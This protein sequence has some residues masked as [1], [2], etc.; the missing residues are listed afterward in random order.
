MAAT[1][2]LARAHGWRARCRLCSVLLVRSNLVTGKSFYIEIEHRVL[3][4]HIE[5]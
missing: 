3:H 2:E 1:A 4:R 5:H